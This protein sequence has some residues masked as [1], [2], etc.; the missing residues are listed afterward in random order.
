MHAWFRL[1]WLADI[2]ALL[3]QAPDQASRLLEVSR[4]QKTERSAMQAL[5]LC[6]RFWDTPLPAQMPAANWPVR[7]LVDM[8]C[9]AMTAGNSVTEPTD[10]RFGNAR[11][12]LSLYLLSSNPRYLWR[13]LHYQL[14][15]PIGR[16]KLPERIRFLFPLLRLPLWVA[17]KLRF[18]TAAHQ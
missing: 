13:E 12:N 7:R 2:G 9:S 11:I 16:E 6:H 14:L 17:S 10:L 8:A 3:A 4:I 18:R 1:K 5:L 15:L